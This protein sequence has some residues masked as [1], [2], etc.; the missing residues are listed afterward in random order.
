ML[1]ILDV[2]D[3]LRLFVSDV[4]DILDDVS[5]ELRLFVS[6]VLNILYDVSNELRLSIIRFESFM[7]CLKLV[8][9]LIRIDKRSFLDR[10]KSNMMNS[11]FRVRS[12]ITGAKLSDC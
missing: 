2:L 11:F 10:L 4:L 8:F 3:E 7:K 12:S 9:H 1:D 5:D 6:D